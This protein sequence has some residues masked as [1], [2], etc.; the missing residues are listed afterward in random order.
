MTYASE[1]LADSPYLY[2]KFDEFF[3]PTAID[4]SGNGYDGTFVGADIAYGKA[5]VMV[6]DGALKAIDF[7][8]IGSTD[9]WV[10]LNP[11]PG[12]F[13]STDITLEYWGTQPAAGGAQLAFHYVTGPGT[14]PTWQAQINLS[15]GTEIQP[16]IAGVVGTV[17]SFSGGVDLRDGLRHHVVVTWRNSDGLFSVWI[18]GVLRFTQIIAIGNTITAGGGL[19]FAQ[20]LTD[21]ATPSASADWR[22]RADHF[23]IYPT[24]LS[25][26][27]IRTHHEAGSIPASYLGVVL[28]DEPDLHW[29]LGEAASGVYATEVLADSPYLYWKLDETAGTQVTDSSGSA[30]HG[31]YSGDYTLD[32][33]PLMPTAGRSV[34]FNDT[35]ANNAIARLNPVPAGFPSTE[36]TYE[37]WLKGTDITNFPVLMNYES[38]A[39][40]D[41]ALLQ[42]N[43]SGDV[44][45]HINGTGGG[46]NVD[47]APAGLEDGLPH[48][49]VVTWRSSDGE[50]RVYIDGHLFEVMTV[51]A[52]ETIAAGGSFILADH[53]DS[54][55][56]PN[57]TVYWN[58]GLLDE[59]AVYPTVLSLARVQAHYMAGVPTAFDEAGTNG[60]VYAGDYVLGASGLVAGADDAVTLNGTGGATGDGRVE[61]GAYNPTGTEISVEVWYKGTALRTVFSWATGPG[62]AAKRFMLEHVTEFGTK[63]LRLHLGSVS[64]AVEVPDLEDDAPHHIV[65]NWDSVTD[66]AQFFVD[67]VP[68]GVGAV[69]KAAPSGFTGTYMVGVA[70]TDDGVV[71]TSGVSSVGVFD[72]FAI[73]PTEL[74]L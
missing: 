53:E 56:V 50:T 64:T 35:G 47:T 46:G 1:V 38:G 29:R 59:V 34:I 62:N 70:Q 10:S 6:G 40:L 4:S 8:L 54:P 42:I 57:G 13:P 68:M 32:Q 24:V 7:N 61:I 51:G 5:P 31:T 52:G 2:W 73:Y 14:P 43:T 25:A 67:G 48:H 65:V 60:G 20:V 72:E 3:G 11:V 55:G 36:L 44:R 69:A 17:G 41:D 9:G 33:A 12:G 63:K 71:D 74:P 27:R 30:R 18:D 19:A 49:L 22:G 28:A 39:G 21:V 45:V 26:A 66:L 16:V 15:S 37:C 58:D 23:A